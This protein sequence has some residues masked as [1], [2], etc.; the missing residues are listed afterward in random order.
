ML[1]FLHLSF[2]LSRYASW[3]IG[4][5]GSARCPPHL[6]WD[7]ILGME[8]SR[9][10]VVGLRVCPV[11]LGRSGLLGDQAMLSLGGNREVIWNRAPIS[12]C[13]CTSW[14]GEENIHSLKCSR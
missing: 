7:L 2:G 8:L 14:Q 10:N 9:P 3:R 5:F 11:Y 1:H 13:L 6:Y 4:W 12:F